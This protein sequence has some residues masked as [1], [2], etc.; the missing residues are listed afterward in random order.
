MGIAGA[1]VAIALA[2]CQKLQT[3]DTL[4]NGK[5]D[6]PWVKTP[7]YYVSKAT[8]ADFVC[9][10]DFWVSADDSHKNVPDKKPVWS[11]DR[12]PGFLRC[13]RSSAER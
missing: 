8:L 4:S 2:N 12:S 10:N 6:M 1:K 7:I 3:A 11:G 5:A 9:K 13:A